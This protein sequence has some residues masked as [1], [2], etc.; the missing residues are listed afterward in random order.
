MLEAQLA[1]GAKLFPRNFAGILNRAYHGK[2][3]Y[4]D[5]VNGNANNNGRQPNKAMVTL[6]A[7]ITAATANKVETIIL[8]PGHAESISTATALNLSKAGIEIIGLGDGNRRPIIT[9]DTANTAT[10]TVSANNIRISNVIFV[11]N[12]L[13]VAALFTLTTATDFQLLNCEVRD[14]DATHNFIAIVVTN[15]TSNNADGLV[16][17]SCTF[18][19]AATSGAVK[20][21]SVLGTNDRWRIANNY[22]TSLTTNAG[23]IIPIATGK[24]LTNFRLLGN[25][26]NVV[27]ATGTGTGYILTTDG[28]T[29]TGFIDG[30]KDHALPT[31]PLFCTASSGFTYG[32]NYHSDQA[33]LAGYLV[34]AADV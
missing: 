25:T 11:A 16:I 24:I 34:P 26:F 15:T 22:Y 3:F 2:V 1:N 7:A 19:L 17:D 31:T 18:L 10:I 14:T 8:L 4:V 20:L 21:A 29:N 33:D 12:F 28:S 32:L 23:A 5:S 30:N 9:L 6:A 13:A 27:N